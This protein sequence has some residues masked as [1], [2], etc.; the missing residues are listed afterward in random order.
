MSRAD[1]I[2]PFQTGGDT[3]V[4][5][6]RVLNPAKNKKNVA[7]KKAVHTSFKT[8]ITKLLSRQIGL[9]DLYLGSPFQGFVGRI[10]RLSLTTYQPV[11]RQQEEEE[12]ELQEKTPKKKDR[13]GGVRSKIYEFMQLMESRWRDHFHLWRL[14]LLL[15]SSAYTAFPRNLAIKT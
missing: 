14:W 4:K 5:P 15:E 2:I 8:K 12:K 10:G 7:R 3:A 6:S 1:T 13:N 11:R 9:G